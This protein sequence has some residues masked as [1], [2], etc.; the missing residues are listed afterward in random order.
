MDKLALVRAGRS[1]HPADDPADGR[2]RDRD[3]V[4]PDPLW[5]ESGASTKSKSAK[6]LIASD[7]SLGLTWSVVESLPVHERIRIGEGDLSE[8]FDNY[9]QSIRNLA[10]CGIHV[11]CYNFMPVSTGRARSSTFP[12]PAAAR[13]CVST[14]RCSPAFDC[15]MLQAQGAEAD[16][17]PAVVAKGKRWFDRRARATATSF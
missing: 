17:A 13:L 15:F 2:E 5:R 9:R 3:R 6:R 8:L 16:Y 7:T 11:V 10:A 1:D 4:A 12:C 14:S